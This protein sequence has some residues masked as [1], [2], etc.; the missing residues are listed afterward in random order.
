MTNRKFKGKY[1]TVN[2]QLSEISKAN[3]VTISKCMLCLH[4]QE[5]SKRKMLEMYEEY[6]RDWV[7]KY[8]ELSKADVM[9]EFV[10]RDLASIGINLNELAP[11]T[12]YGNVVDPK[13]RE[14]LVDN[15]G[16][17]CLYLNYKIHYGKKRLHGIFDMMKRYT[18]DP[19]AD[20][21]KLL[22]VRCDEV[23]PDVQERMGKPVK[24]DRAE[25]RR[26]RQ[27]MEGLRAFQER[28]KNESGT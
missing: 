9:H 15:F 22:G 7:S 19:A 25:L 17:F 18:G 11:Y 6:S 1:F 4:T 16:I 2:M 5:V 8:N 3:F 13:Q 14:A 20:I 24:F 28:S 23:L 10:Q 26:I 27:D 21:N 12:Y